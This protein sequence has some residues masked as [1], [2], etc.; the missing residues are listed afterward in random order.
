LTDVTRLDLESAVAKLVGGGE[1]VTRRPHVYRSSFAIEELDLLRSDGTMSMLILKDLGRSRLDA[2]ARHAKPLGLHDPRREIDVYESILSR[3]DLGTAACYGSVVEPGLD[4]YWLLLERVDGLPLWQFDEPAVWSAVARWAAR[5]HA[6]AAPSDESRLLR[7]DDAVCWRWFESALLAAPDVGLEAF[8]SI[9]RHAV[10]QIANVRVV[11]VHGDLYPSNVL[12]ASAGRICPV[13]WEL[14]GLSTGMLDL[15]ALTTGLSDDLV[16][17]LVETYLDE[18]PRAPAEDPIDLLD[19][20]R[21][22]LAVKW[23]GWS[24]RWTPPPEHARD[25]AVD[26][27]AAAARLDSTG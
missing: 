11:F 10:E 20:C 1:L 23:L 4:R 6:T 14:A 9:Y 2:N 26:A 3:L 21:L 18:L 13:D 15:A 16:S 27:L 7:Y 17:L 22:C 12:V 24:E 19:C 5:L 8:R 25:W